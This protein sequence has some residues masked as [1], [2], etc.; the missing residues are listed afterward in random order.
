M[1]HLWIPGRRSR[2]VYEFYE[3]GFDSRTIAAFDLAEKCFCNAVSLVKGRRPKAHKRSLGIFSVV[4]ACYNLLGIQYIEMKQF[5]HA[6]KSL[7]EAIQLRREL[8]RLFP[9]DRENE[10]Y[11]GGALCN[12]GHACA[13]TNANEAADFYQQSLE[14][15]RQ[16]NQTCE[17]GYWDEERQSWWCS[18]L[19]A[20]GQALDMQWVALAPRFI[21]NAADGLRSVTSDPP[22]PVST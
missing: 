7:D 13:D 9:K 19:E 4:A 10:V 18:Q 15:L 3:T 8:R 11:L 14:V 1:R 5:G 22:R 16:P 2:L 6:R 21:D 12:R 17:C 20:I